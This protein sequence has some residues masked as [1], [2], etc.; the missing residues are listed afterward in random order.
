MMGSNGISDEF[1][2]ARL[3]GVRTYERTHDVH[4]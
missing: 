4:C 1:G 3:E 2:D